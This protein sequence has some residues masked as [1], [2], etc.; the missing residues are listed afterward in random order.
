MVFKF[1]LII[2]PLNLKK[3]PDTTMWITKVFEEVKKTNNI[4][5]LLFTGTFNLF[6][7]RF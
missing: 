7:Y 4:H 2:I 6:D 3:L 1:N 5:K